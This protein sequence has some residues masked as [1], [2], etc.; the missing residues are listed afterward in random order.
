MTD[1]IGRTPSSIMMSSSF[2]QTGQLIVGHISSNRNKNLALMFE[3]CLFLSKSVTAPRVKSKKGKYV[4]QNSRYVA[5]GWI[6]SD[7]VEREGTPITCVST[8]A[9]PS[10]FVEIR[11]LCCSS[12]AWNIST[13]HICACQLRRPLTCSNHFCRI[14]AGEK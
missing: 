5:L 4:T 13:P 1:K 7:P 12:Q 10:T 8:V 3:P 2:C 11:V 9:A 14:G 6:C